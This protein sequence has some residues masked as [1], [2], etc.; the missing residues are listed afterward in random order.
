MLCT[1]RVDIRGHNVQSTHVLEEPP[2]VAFRQDRG[3]LS[4]FQGPGNDLVVDI[5]EIGN[6][7]HVVSLVYQVPPDGIED[8]IGPAMSYMDVVIDLG[9]ADVHPDLAFLQGLELLFAPRGRVVYPEHHLEHL[10]GC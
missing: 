7:L 9:T 3:V 6:V 10:F 2:D 8:N 1:L 4:R 5:R